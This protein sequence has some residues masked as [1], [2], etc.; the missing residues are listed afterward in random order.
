MFMT[1]AQIAAEYKVSRTAAREAVGRLRGVGILESRQ[2]KGLVVRKAD[3]IRLLAHSLSGCISSP[4]DFQDLAQFR[5]ALEIGAIELAIRHATEEQIARLERITLEMEQA[6]QPGGRA[7]P[8]SKMEAQFHGL[9]LEMTGSPMIAGM[10]RVLRDFFAVTQRETVSREMVEQV[11]R[12]HRDLFSAIRDRDLERA[13]V[14]L[15][16]HFRHLLQPRPPEY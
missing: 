14:I 1:E 15:R 5:Y 6:L 3:P 11:H 4:E 13:R 8:H 7:E 9:I 10:Q 12:D 16:M 2:G